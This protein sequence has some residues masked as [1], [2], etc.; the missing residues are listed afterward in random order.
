VSSKIISVIIPILDIELTQ[1]TLMP[2]ATGESNILLSLINKSNF[3]VN[4]IKA[5]IDISGEALI[6]ETITAT[7]QPNEVYS[8]ILSAGIIGSRNGTSY[9]CVEL[10]V[11]GD[12][13]VRNNK[14]C[15]NNDVATVVMAPYPNPGSENVNLEWISTTATNAE[16]HIFDPTGR[17]VYE[18]MFF[19][20]DPGLHHATISV[21]L[22]NP[23]MYYVFFVSEG[24]RR[25]FPF[26]IRR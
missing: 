16:I 17:K 9:L 11:D 21:G 6:S 4:N 26:V 25:S 22:L 18:N 7:I 23:G 19:D 24:V 8:Q 15:L 13:D 5:I 14:K 3:P 2:S 1:L 10:V 20:L 12:G